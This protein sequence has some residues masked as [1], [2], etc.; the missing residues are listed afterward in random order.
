VRLTWP[1]T[2]RSNEMRLIEAAVF[3]ADSSGIIVSGAAG[4]G[5]S[6]IAREA[7]NSAES[8]G[9]EVRWI[10]GTSSA[11]TLPLGALASWAGQTGRDG[12]AL[13]RGAIESITSAPAGKT[14]VLGVDDVPLLDDLS[15]FVVH[16]IIQRRA[17]KVVLTVRDGEPI[18]AGTRELWKGGQ[19]DRL[20][21]E[22]L[23]QA[24]IAALVS[25][26]LVGPLDP[27][28]A[29]RLWT[30]TR[31][32][33]LYLRNI[34]EQEVACERL[35][36]LDGYWRWLG[37]PVVP[38]GLVEL[39]EERIGALPA[40]VSEVIDALA[41]G[42]PVELGSLTRITDP[43]AVEQA[44]MRGLITLDQV[45]GR[46]EA[47]LAHP[48]YGE[49][50]RSRTA[51]TRL[52]R[53]RGLIAAELAASHDHDDIRIVVRRAALSV[54]SN[55][56]P[57]PDL[58][59]RA[60]HGATWLADLPLAER[61]AD[62]AIRAGA[63]PEASAIRGRALTWLSRGREADEVFAGIAMN[64]LSDAERARL[65]FLR[66]GNMQWALQDPAR[67]KEI[68]DDASD[69]TPP[70]S[71]GCIDAFLAVYWAAMGKPE[72]AIKAWRN[73]VLDELPGIVG[74]E[75]P[76][77]IGQAAGEMGRAAEAAA[78][79]DA[80]Y[81]ITSRFLDA[82]QMRFAIGDSHVNAL[83]L[84]GQIEPARDTAQRL[85]DQSADMPGGVELISRGV[86]GRA[87][88]A[89]GRLDTACLLLQP[90]VEVLFGSGQTGG[91]YAFG[92]RFKIP[93]TIALAVRGSTDDAAAA[94]ATLGHQRFPSF[95]YVDW[96][97]ALAQAWVAA[98][99]GAVTEAIRMLTTVAD[100]ARAD[101]RFAAEVMCLQTA[102]QF[103]DRSSGR[104]LRQLEGIVEGPRVGTAAR[105]A[106]ALHAGDGD[107]LAAV[108]EQ[109]EDMGDVIAAVDSAAHAA[110]AYRR[111]DLRGSALGCSTR[112]EALAEQC[113]GAR[114]PALR[115]A[116]ERLPLTDREREIVML[117]GEGL[118][119][120]DIAARLT[121]SIRTVED[122]VHKAMAKTGTASRH[123][124][125]ALLPRR[126]HGVSG[127]DRP[128]H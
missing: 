64:D 6:R 111:R 40:S 69:T 127:K 38:P 120:R 68:I 61:L 82:A 19:F 18:P 72:A 83:L 95:R 50:R 88:L 80:G 96:E 24:E 104:R 2:G 63:G 128:P 46:V 121:L 51:P 53:L 62:G 118:S 100:T 52:R 25:A 54:D 58:L 27:Q 7:L 1:L 99:Q 76:W 22:P 66:A 5:K 93:F 73:I 41:V 94:Y 15:T 106:E 74:A 79:A 87:A 11:R 13:V 67:A 47:R 20:D 102:T 90:V 85:C 29:E 12:L 14:V 114:T 97:R 84:S 81:A 21:L 109:F 115:Q 34:V 119:N 16:Q 92:Y 42:E 65:A 108:S 70:A 10:A 103:G 30:L 116:A 125:A 37:D 49:V 9:C 45:G 31:G 91:F 110:I 77:A 71:R 56:E 8:T 36:S 89:A 105:F 28:V 122:H 113:G 59:V 124:L 4:V 26:T 43:A 32:N 126:R 35:A 86:A 75:V 17:A 3:D 44:D 101:G 23:S 78:V 123:D 48:L 57:D 39:I 33:P 117:L 112:A 107:E 60:A 55:L 98:A